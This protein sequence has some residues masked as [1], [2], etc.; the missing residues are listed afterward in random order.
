MASRDYETELKQLFPSGEVMKSE[1]RHLWVNVEAGA[2]R[3]AVADVKGKLG[4]RHLATIVAEDMRDHFLVNYVMAGEVVVVLKVRV[5]REKPEVPSLAPVIDGALV[6]EREI[7]DLFGIVPTEHPDLRR[8][9]LP[10]G[11]PQGLYPLRKDAVIP[12]ATVPE[13]GEGSNA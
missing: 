5:D 6:Y 8:Q 9:V 4:I 1:E 7:H 3:Q 10:E 12:K 13:G 11:W 2:L